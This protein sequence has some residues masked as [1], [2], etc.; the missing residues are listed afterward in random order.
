MRQHLKTAISSAQLRFQL[1][2]APK[3]IFSLKLSA[4]KASVIPE[5]LLEKASQKHSP[6]L[7]HTQD[8][9]GRSIEISK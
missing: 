5:I 2:S 8:S 9:L 3:L 6:L 1:S 7:S 4:L